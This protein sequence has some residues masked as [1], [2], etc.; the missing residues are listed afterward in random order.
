MADMEYGGIGARDA[1][2]LGVEATAGFTCLELLC[3]IPLL[4]I[5][6]QQDCFDKRVTSKKGSLQ[7]GV[8]TG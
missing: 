4:R 2:L 8:A 3:D 6:A 5:K 7:D 1:V